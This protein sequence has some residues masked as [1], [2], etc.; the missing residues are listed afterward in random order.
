M[1]KPLAF[2]EKGA[3]DELVDAAHSAIYDE[4]FPPNGTFL[5]QRR[6]EAEYWYHRA[7]DAN[8]EGKRKVTYVGKVGDP[9]AETIVSRRAGDR[10]NY[11]VMSRTASM[12]RRILPSPEPIEG[13][14]AKAF[15]K[16]GLFHR[17]A[18]LIGSV[19][20]Q[21]YGGF[22]GSRLSGDLQRTQDFDLAQERKLEKVDMAVRLDGLQ[23]LDFEKLVRQADSSFRP[24]HNAGYPTSLPTAYRNDAGYRVELLTARRDGRKPDVAPAKVSGLTGV[25]AQPLN[26]MDFLT[27]DPV[28]SVLLYGE[29]I[30]VTVPDPARYAIH[31]VIISQIRGA[32]GAGKRGKDLGQSE[33]ILEALAARG[34][35]GDAARAW[36]EAWGRTK[37]LRP[38]IASGALSLRDRA[39]EILGSACV[40]YGIEPFREGE[41]PDASLRKILP[42]RAPAPQARERGKKGIGD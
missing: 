18:V 20:Y 8:A 23:P 41:R 37:S 30:A 32:S 33:E 19:A 40:R 7:Y 28:R 2:H 11:A 9:D 42:Q 16:A 24:E 34:T 35:A 27:K 10:A 22:L 5:K 21:S 4:R 3:F 29:G 25:A 17:G 36:E 1:A 12:L 6:G 26:L 15:A 13:E 39:L 31:K 38:T 14:L